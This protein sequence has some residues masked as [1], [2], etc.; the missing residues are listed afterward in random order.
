MTKR[1]SFIGEFKR[2]AVRLLDA[3]QKQRR[4]LPVS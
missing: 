2:E 1:K 3:S 4:I